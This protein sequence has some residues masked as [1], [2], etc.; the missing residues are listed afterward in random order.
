MSKYSAVVTTAELKPEIYSMSAE[1]TSK[2]LTM[3]FGRMVKQ[4]SKVC[5]VH[6]GG[7]WEM[8]SHETTRIGDRLVVS[9]LLHR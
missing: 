5:N 7:R 1:D 6:E 8:V 3:L 9:F 2:N 4:A